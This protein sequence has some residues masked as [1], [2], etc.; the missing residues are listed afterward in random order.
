ML[1]HYLQTV[2]DHNNGCVGVT[3]SLVSH[4]LAWCIIQTSDC[5]PWEHMDELMGE[6]AKQNLISRYV[7]R[8]V[9]AC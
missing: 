9:L 5:F 1:A 7:L 3:V 4:I 2:M 6:I 8:D